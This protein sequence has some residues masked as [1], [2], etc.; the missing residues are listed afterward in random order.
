MTHSHERGEKIT[1]FFVARRNSD[2]TEG[3]GGMLDM[4]F[5]TDH[6]EAFKAVRGEAVQGCGDGDIVIRTYYRCLTCP[7]LIEV[8]EHIYHGDDYTKKNILGK[9][10]RFA[11]FMPDG[12]RADYSDM[13]Q[14]PEWEEYLRLKAKFEK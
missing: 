8:N 3:R 4:G 10:G 14:D 6:K 9:P 5:F 1:E 13:V 7:A 11:N 2:Q 12:W